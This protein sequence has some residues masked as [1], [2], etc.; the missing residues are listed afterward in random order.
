MPKILAAILDK[1]VKFNQAF[2]MAFNNQEEAKKE[3]FFNPPTITF[4]IRPGSGDVYIDAIFD[5]YDD[6]EA[7]E[8][9]VAMMVKLL[10]SLNSAENL[11][12]VV[13][14]AMYKE[15]EQN[16]EDILFKTVREIHQ[17]YDRT[18]SL[19]NELEKGQEPP[20]VRPSMVFG[21]NIRPQ[22]GPH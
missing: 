15:Y 21:G 9:S 5:Y 8:L 10:A 13:L 14:E 1:I 6:E 22:Q 12:D 17:L 11:G 16:K 18:T 2:W 3:V 20:A 19:M 7:Q 4:G